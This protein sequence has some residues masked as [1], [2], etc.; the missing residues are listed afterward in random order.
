MTARTVSSETVFTSKAFSLQSDRVYLTNGLEATMHLIRHSG[1]V[2]LLPIPD[3]GYIVLVR[4]YRYSID[5]WTWE[6]P[7]GTIKLGETPKQAAIRECH[8]EIEK[9][10][11][12][13]ETLGK[14]YP[15]PGYCNELM[16]FFRLTELTEPD[17]NAKR[18]DDEEIEAGVFSLDEA[19]Q[20][21][22]NA[23]ASDM[24]TAL[25]LNLL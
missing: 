7:A 6:V 4:Q 13:I 19:W 14:F 8:E 25:G 2:V 22:R 10:P 24:K 3:P 11:G 15:T 16:T 23:E 17:H 20:L 18:D 5:R 21:V 1:S 9:L 12:H